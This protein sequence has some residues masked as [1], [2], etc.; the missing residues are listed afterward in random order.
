M[1]KDE[2]ARLAE[3]ID[4][5]MELPP[6]NP[7]RNINLD[8]HMGHAA[9][10]PY[11]ALEDRM[12]VLHGDKWASWEDLKAALAGVEGEGNDIEQDESGDWVRYVPRTVE[13]ITGRDGTREAL[14]EDQARYV[15][16]SR[17]DARARSAG[18]T[19]TD[20]FDGFT[21]WRRGQ[22]P[23][24]DLFVAQQ[25]QARRNLRRVRLDGDVPLE[26]ARDRRAAA[27]P[28]AEKKEG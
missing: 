15:A 5:E 3:Q 21:W 28:A 11:A 9:Q 13:V 10:R 14:I 16:L 23:E 22:K 8:V 7:V 12:G 6:Q 26:E 4:R 17:A 19:E 24:R 2:M 20:Y 25:Q 1:P 27:R 18:G